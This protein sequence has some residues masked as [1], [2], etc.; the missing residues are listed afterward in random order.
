MKESNKLIQKANKAFDTEMYF[1][2]SELYKKGYDK[3]KY[4]DK[5]APLRAE[6][7]F[8]QA[9][10]F[11]QLGKFKQAE[12]HY[13]KAIVGK[14]LK[15]ESIYWYAKMLMMSQKYEKALKEFEKFQKKSTAKNIE[16]PT[17]ERKTTIGILSCSLAVEAIANPT[18]YNIRKM[19]VFCS[20]F[21]DYSP[22]YG[23][24]SSKIYFVSNRKGSSN[25]KTDDRTGKYFTDI[26]SSY[27]KK[28]EKWSTPKADTSL[29]T[30]NH[31]GTLCLSQNGTTMFFTVCKS[32][33]KKKLGCKI[34]ISEY[35][36]AKK[37]KGKWA[38][39]N[40]LNITE[41]NED[42]KRVVDSN[43]TIGHP[44]IS[45]DGK[46]IIFSAEIP[47]LQKDHDYQGGKDLWRVKKW[48]DKDGK[49]VGQWSLPENLG[50]AVNTPGDEMFPF[51]HPDGTLYFA[52]DG[53]A[54]LGGLDIFRAKPDKVT[55]EYLAKSENLLYPINSS[56]DDFGMIV[57][58]GTERGY[59]SSNRRSWTKTT[60]KNQGKKKTNGSDNIYFFEMPALV[61]TLQGEI[62]D[63]KT[64][65]FITGA[66]VKLV[67][68][69]NSAVEVTTDN[70][71]NYFFDLTPLISYEIIVSRKGYMR[72]KDTVITDVFEVNTDIVRNITLFPIL[73]DIPLPRIY[74]DFAKWDLRDTSKLDLDKVYDVMKEHPEIVIQL[75]S[76]TD[77]RGENLFNMELS[78][79]RA[80]ICIDYLIQKGIDSLRMIASGKGE[81]EPYIITKKDETKYK[82]KGLINKKIFKQGDELTKLH[83]NNILEE[84]EYKEIAHQFNRRTTFNIIS[85]TYNSEFEK[86]F[87]NSTIG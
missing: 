53:W 86:L 28:N 13:K 63:E 51:I 79:K 72:N 44:T 46:F 54:G 8:R 74:Y 11:R 9:E 52:S 71:G 38:K 80:D 37:G 41:K 81:S 29:N 39:P 4:N 70:T 73:K 34:C 60:G 33:K 78:Q 31:E 2:A 36:S 68:D 24:D 16:N 20:Q 67:G 1:D 55:G 84:D 76:H 59:F 62:T 61:L 22:A 19:N 49:I 82:K 42:G 25:D 5:N 58:K 14:C 75:N 7:Y 3:L 66:N 35:K 21:D 64:E 26:Y 47:S 85:Q 30:D 23:K 10:C 12:I 40:T 27:I 56:A 65:D 50:P 45:S 87:R 15:V 83:I 32:E 43:V 6:I 77:F 17:Y 18:R 48:S 69:D 57:E